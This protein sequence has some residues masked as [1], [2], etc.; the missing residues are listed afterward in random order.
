MQQKIT[1][2][3]KIA[4]VAA[5]IHGILFS[6]YDNC[7]NKI[8]TLEYRYKSRAI[9]MYFSPTKSAEISMPNVPLNK[10]SS[11]FFAVHTVHCKTAQ[12]QK[13]QLKACFHIKNMPAQH[14]MWDNLYKAI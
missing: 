7:R 13:V 14:H 11:C 2:Q 12:N 3:Q 6:L 9:N 4:V 1:M 10:E 5:M 8:W